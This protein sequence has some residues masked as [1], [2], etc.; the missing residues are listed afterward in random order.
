MTTIALQPLAALTLLLLLPAAACAPSGQVGYGA[1]D[2][3]A[4]DALHRDAPHAAGL[5]TAAVPDGP[6]VTASGAS[7]AP[8]R[9]PVPD[10]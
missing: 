9:H 8:F 10:R 2:R 5:R 6:R 4:M 1:A 7:G 3:M